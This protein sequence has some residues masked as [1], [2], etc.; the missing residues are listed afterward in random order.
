MKTIKRKNILLKQF[1]VAGSLALSTALVMAQASNT[2][3]N[4]G[5]AQVNLVSDVSSNAP[6]TDARLLNPWGIVAGADHVWVN[7]NHSSL[8]TA[9]GPHGRPFQFAISVPAP[10]GGP[11][12]PTGLA[13][14]QTSG[15]VITNGM[16]HGPSSFLMATEEGT[17]TAWNQHFSGSNAVIVVDNSAGGAVYKGLAITRD[18]NGSP[19]IYAANFHAGV[20]DVFD[21]RFHLV[22]SFTDA[23]LPVN[24]AP[25]NVRAIRGRLFVSF[26]KQL[27]P[28]AHDDQAGPGNGFVDIF[29][30]DGTLLR[31]FAAQGPLDSPWGMAV[32]PRHFGKFSRALL[33]GNFGDGRINAYDLLTGKFLG[34]L[35]QPNGDALEIQGLWGLTFEREE[36]ADRECEFE[37]GRLYFTAGPNGEADGLLGIIHPVSPNF[38]PTR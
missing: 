1:L 13:L 18:T 2:R 6:E 23:N 4:S 7:D 22:S 5:Y 29:D 25:F 34:Q 38:P 10:G 27:P 24:F 17:I 26:A 9:Y 11:G 36:P 21:A 37:A 30:T 12:S 20:V 35:T 16:K 32:A 14:N 31:Q 15:F 33:V 19:Q 28:D 3:T 8:V